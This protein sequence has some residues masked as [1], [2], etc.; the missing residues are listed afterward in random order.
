MASNQPATQA[1][2]YELISFKIRPISA[3]CCSKNSERLKNFGDTNVQNINRTDML[4]LSA[5][6][7]VKE[8]LFK[9]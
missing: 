3:N 2:H 1:G 6:C 5:T 4:Y 9:L 8:T 7:T